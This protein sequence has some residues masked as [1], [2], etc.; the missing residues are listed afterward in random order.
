MGRKSNHVNIYIHPTWS[1]NKV[2]FYFMTGKA[3]SRE[4]GIHGNIQILQFYT[5]FPIILSQDTCIA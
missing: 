2:V 1:L 5:V 3:I 4:T